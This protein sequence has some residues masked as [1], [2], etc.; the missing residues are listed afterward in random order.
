MSESR[1]KRKASKCGGRNSRIRTS[2]RAPKPSRIALEATESSEASSTLPALPI[3]A[4]DTIVIPDSQPSPQAT[5]PNE[6]LSSMGSR[7]LSSQTT[8]SNASPQASQYPPM[9]EAESFLNTKRSLATRVIH[10]PNKEA[11]MLEEAT[12][13]QSVRLANE[14]IFCS[15]DSFL[16]FFR[17]VSF[18]H[19]LIAF[20]S[21]R[22]ILQ[23]NGQPSGQGEALYSEWLQ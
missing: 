12:R 6:Q 23:E 2:N 19:E 17:K 11:A 18:G 15:Y 16:N 13:L 8:L 4:S 20:S 10:A 7:G 22:Q 1:N 5:V 14:A 21:G 9:S 3:Q